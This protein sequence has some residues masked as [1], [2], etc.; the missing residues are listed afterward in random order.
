ML[1]KYPYSNMH[2]LNLDWIIEE[3]KAGREDIEDFRAYLNQGFEKIVEE[4]IEENL[5]NIFGTALYNAENE[6]I[7]LEL[8]EGV[9]NE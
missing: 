5:Q 2:E 4:Y 7:V 6:E 9:L 8:K 3:V 1:H